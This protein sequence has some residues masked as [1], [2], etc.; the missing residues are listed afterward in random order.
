MSIE[1]GWVDWCM[2]AVLVLSFV[3][4]ALRGLVFEVLTVVGWFV[5]WFAALW[6]G[7]LL[8]PHLPIGTSGSLL[9]QGAAFALAFI[10]V[11]IVWGLLSRLVRSLIHAT[12]LSAIDRLLGAVFGVLR[13]AILLLLLAVFVAHTPA[14]NS[15]PWQ[16][17]I[18]AAWLNT[19]LRALGPLWPA[20]APRLLPA[21]AANSVRV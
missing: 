20:G 11:L 9:N 8:A 6:A 16:V 5:A 2:L 12:P 17:S 4:G 13:G 14:G 1:I 10:A 7:P 19:A 3:V 21:G 18:G 15:A